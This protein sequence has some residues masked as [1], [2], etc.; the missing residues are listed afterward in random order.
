MKKTLIFLT[1]GSLAWSGRP[2]SVDRPGYSIIT[3][4]GMDKYTC[5]VE[6][7]E[8]S[9]CREDESGRVEFDLDNTAKT[10]TWWEYTYPNSPDRNKAKIYKYEPESKYG[11][12]TYNIKTDGT[13]NAMVIGY[14]YVSDRYL[15]LDITERATREH[16]MTV[17][18]K[19]N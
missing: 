17:W 19:S 2:A 7:F 1:L 10:I 5:N 9:N 13:V 11:K 15:T 18:H 4:K 6:F 8:K 16:K 14:L 12:L 3:F